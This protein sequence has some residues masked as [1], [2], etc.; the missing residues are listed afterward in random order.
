[1]RDFERRNR[2]FDALVNAPGLM[3]LG[4]NTNHFD[5]HPAVVEAMTA[6][7]AASE[8]HAYAPPAGLEELRQLILQDL[9]L[10]PAQAS[11]LVTDGAVQALYTACRDLAEPGTN[12][13]TTDP[14]WK[15]PMAFARSSGATVTQIPIYRPD[16]GYKLTPAQLDAAVDASTRLIYIVDPNNP[17]GTCH[18][19]EEIEAFAAIARRAGAWLVHDCTYRHF[20]DRHTLVARFYPEGTVTV[21]S[22]SKWLGLAGMR[23]GALV[24]HPELLER[25]A[26]APPNNLGSNIVTQRAAIAGLRTRDEWFPGINLR[27]RANQ[28][29]IVEAS[30]RVPGLQ[31]VNYP[32]QANLLVMECIDAG[33]TPEALCREFRDENVMI[34]QGAY[35]TAAFGHRFVKVSTTV[36]ENWVE[37]FCTLL[38]SMVERA[39]NSTGVSAMF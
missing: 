9:A 24:A 16:N 39:R 4:Q 11:V 3:W 7:I 2:Y 36:P 13:V 12:F 30:R 28:A 32:S 5:P 33:I 22:F 34:R 15:W 26:A 23:L 1:M 21:Y 25:L 31:V 20:A 10:D 27:Q 6:S 35:H 19:A 29:R 38:P 17:L 8:Y 18:S 14:G 37:A